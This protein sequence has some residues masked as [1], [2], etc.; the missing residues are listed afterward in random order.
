MIC[1]GVNGVGE[2]AE[3]RSGK[4][5][6]RGSCRWVR[7]AWVEKNPVGGGGGGGSARG[8]G[9]GAVADGEGD[10]G[11]GDGGDG[12]GVREEV[13]AGVMGEFEL[14]RH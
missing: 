4:G 12:G 6:M 11:S 8:H 13:T 2:G 14:R 7:K 10:G 5:E 9:R 3:M 1:S